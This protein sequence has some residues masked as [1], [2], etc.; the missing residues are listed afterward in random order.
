MFFRGLSARRSGRGQSVVELA[1]VLPVV[2]LIVV[3]AIDFGRAFSGY[4]TLTNASR[5][6]ANYAASHPT[7]W[8]T[9]GDPAERDKYDELILRDTDMANCELA[10]V[11]PPAPTFTDGADAGTTRTDVSDRVDVALSCTFKPITP[12]IGAILGNSVVM[13]ANSDFAVRAGSVAGVPIPPAVPV[14]SPVGTPAGTPSATPSPTPACP[15]LSFTAT[16]TSNRGNP[17]RMSF[18]GSINPSSSGW[19]WT[20]SGAFSGNTQ[21]ESNHNF[22]ASGPVTVTLT[23]S[24]SPCS[25]STT[26][27]VNVP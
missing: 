20:W 8:G 9:P 15:T 21:N 23:A 26:Q 13:S 16:D 18:A 2:L 10:P 25:M 22:A 12:L 5:I 4:V 27:T 7:A 6:G 17:H 14:P 24:K 1:L 11:D 19:T 3:V